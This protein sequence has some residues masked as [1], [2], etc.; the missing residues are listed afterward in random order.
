MW[1]HKR[2]RSERATHAH[3]C[4]IAARTYAWLGRTQCAS[5][6]PTYTVGL[7]C[8]AAACLLAGRELDHAF[9][10]LGL[11]ALRVEAPTAHALQRVSKRALS[12]L[13]RG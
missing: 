3:G 6:E 5:I 13:E 7:A 1:A 2:R 12:E 11:D 9:S 10:A 8:R 4:G